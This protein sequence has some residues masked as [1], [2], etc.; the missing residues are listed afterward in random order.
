MKILVYFL[1]LTIATIMVLYNHK[2]F[3]E[4]NKVVEQV[5]LVSSM[6]EQ[7][8]R[9]RYLL[10]KHFTVVNSSSDYSIQQF[11]DLKESYVFDSGFGRSISKD[12]YPEIIDWP[13]VEQTER[14][15]E[16]LIAQFPL[17]NPNEV[18]EN[19]SFNLEDWTNRM[20]DTLDQIQQQDIL[21]VSRLNNLMTNQLAKVVT[22]NIILVATMFLI[23]LF[24]NYKKNKENLVKKLELNQSL[25]SREKALISSKKVLISL[26]E[27]LSQEKNA[28]LK[29]SKMFRNVNEKLEAKNNDMEQF[30]YTVSHDLK[31]PLVTIGSFSKSLS[32]QLIEVLNEKQVHKFKRIEQ[33]VEEMQSLLADLLE[34]SRVMTQEIEKSNIN[35]RQLLDSL[36]IPL[37]E[38][39]SQSKARINIIEPILEVYANPRLLGLCITN[40]VSNAVHHR[41]L[42]RTLEVEISTKMSAEGGMLSVKDNG[43]GIDEKEHDRIF[44]VFERLSQSEGSGVGLAIVKA[45]VDKHDGIIQLDS[46]PGVGSTFSLIFP[47]VAS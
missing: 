2:A 45:V 26:M 14:Y 25:V 19:P 18:L 10:Q 28:A 23:V 20:V 29:L 32:Q 40:L 44:K 22:V 21:L 42:D 30:I 8:G 34:I 38:L 4:V 36:L 47:F 7:R 24:Y 27:D 9:Q 16:S 11:N 6:L 5:D 43:V 41:D 13:K 12:D 3:I 39:I 31:A 15:I 35:T 33:N 1:I 37:E 17:D 46:T